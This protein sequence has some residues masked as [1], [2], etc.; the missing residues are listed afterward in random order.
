[1]THANAL[2]RGASMLLWSALTTHA[3]A[4]TTGATAYVAVEGFDTIINTVS[5]GAGGAHTVADRLV[6]APGGEPLV[7]VGAEASSRPGELAVTGIALGYVPTT[8]Q[9]QGQAI[10]SDAFAIT[11]PGHGPSET[12]TFS[13]TVGVSGQLLVDFT[14]RAYAITRVESSVHLDP[15]TG[16][17][18]G[19]VV[20]K[21]SASHN[22]GYDI[23]DTRI[24]NENFFLSFVDVP[25]TFGQDIAVTLDLLVVAGANLID[26]GATSNAKADYFHTMTWQG[27]SEVRDEAGNLLSTYSAT[28]ADSGFDFSRPVP[29]PGS[30]LLMF[31]GLLTVFCWRR[32]MRRD[33]LG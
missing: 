27:L 11:A 21:G 28:S 2:Q 1:M 14:G 24:G 13:G 22:A 9:A 25:F 5:A 10:W 30:A 26:P 18:G 29:E 12:G 8:A 4:T 20:L 7:K 6:T 3:I 15:R 19:V 32:A 23:G 31:G 16:Y 33:G 17:N